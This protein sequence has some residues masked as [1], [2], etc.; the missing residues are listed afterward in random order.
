M[1]G[2]LKTSLI[3]CLQPGVCLSKKIILLSGDMSSKAKKSTKFKTT[4]SAVLIYQVPMIHTAFIK[5]KKSTI[6]F[7]K[8]TSGQHPLPYLT[9]F[10]QAFMLLFFKIFL[11]LAFS[12]LPQH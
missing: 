11:V 8:T 1:A 10:S 7:Q 6:D 2:T 12:S 5:K 4:F 9:L 3:S